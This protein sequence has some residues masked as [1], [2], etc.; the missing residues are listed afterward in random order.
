MLSNWY[1]VWK[2]LVFIGDIDPC[3]VYLPDGSLNAVGVGSIA[4][5]VRSSSQNVLII[6]TPSMTFRC[7]NAHQ[8]IEYNSWIHLDK[9]PLYFPIQLPTTLWTPGRD[10]KYSF[11]L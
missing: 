3:F 2:G 6:T 4:E 1:P 8:Q 9:K 11:N 7:A 5:A 10:I